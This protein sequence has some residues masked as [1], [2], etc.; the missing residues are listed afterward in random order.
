MIRKK[1]LWETIERLESERD[2]LVAE[3]KRLVAKNTELLLQTETQRL[4]AKLNRMA[5]WEYRE[6]D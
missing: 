1:D 4:N 3:N 5:K 2:D 6:S